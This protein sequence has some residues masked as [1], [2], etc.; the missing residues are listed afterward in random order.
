MNMAKRLAILPNFEFPSGELNRLD[1]LFF[2]YAGPLYRFKTP[3]NP[4]IKGDKGQNSNTWKLMLQFRKKL[5]IPVFLAHPRF[6][7]GFDQPDLAI[8]KVLKTLNIGIEVN[9]GERNSIQRDGQKIYHFELKK[10][11]YTESAKLKIPFITGT[12]T[13]IAP[14]GLDQ[15]LPA[16]EYLK[17]IGG[18]LWDVPERRNF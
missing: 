12:D 14:E 17:K 7:T 18:T 3:P 6:D 11:V 10:G 16:C 13:H 15:L 8:A 2:E 1:Y 9:S 5:R 4:W